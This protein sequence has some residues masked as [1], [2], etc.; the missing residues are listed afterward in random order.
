MKDAGQLTLSLA[1]IKKQLSQSV[2][3][4]SMDVLSAWEANRIE[5][6][7]VAALPIEEPIHFWLLFANFRLN[8]GLVAL[9]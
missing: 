5:A 1:Q 9:Y 6:G 4:V 8:T 2:F 3:N 7:N